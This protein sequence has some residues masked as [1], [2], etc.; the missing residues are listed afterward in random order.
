MIK[1]SIR[2]TVLHKTILACLLLVPFCAASN[3]ENSNDSDYVETHT[4]TREFVSGGNFHVR[5]SVG[6]LRVT[7]GDANKIRLR[8]TVK[9]QL[10]RNMKEATVEFEVHGNNANLEFHAPSGGNTNFDVELEV[11]QNTNLDVHEKVGD[12]TIDEIDGDKD[13]DLNVGDI[14]VSAAQNGYRAIHASTGIGDV[15]GNGY[16]ESGG[17]LGK[18]LKYHGDGKYE[19]RAHVSVG[20]ITLEGK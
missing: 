11:P 3:G 20:D 4:D 18:T 2:F 1:S 16:G 19:L 13:L 9:S 15:H 14:R 17:W 7:R 8:Y 12:L 6:D 10:Q 5:L